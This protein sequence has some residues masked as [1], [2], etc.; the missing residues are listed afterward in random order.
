MT[1]MDKLTILAD[2]AKYDVACTSSGSD[3]AN[4]PGTL[5]S[6][7]AGGICHSFASDG[8]CIS[9]LKVLYSNAC[10]YD[11]SYCV[12]RSSNDV[13]RASFEQ[14]ELASLTIEFYRRNYLEGLFLS[15]G[16]LKNPNYTCELMH[17]ALSILRNEYN[18][19]GYIHVKAIPGADD[20]LIHALG[21]LADRI[22]VNIELPSRQSLELLAPDKNREDILRPMS[23]IKERIM[24]NRNE[25]AL[26]KRV[27]KFAPAGQA[28]QL[29]VGATPETDHQI[30]KLS[31]ALYKKY[32]LKRVFFS[33]YM[34]MGSSANLPSTDIKP[35]LLREHRLYQSDWLMRFYGFKADEIVSE[36]HPNLNPLIDPKCNWAINN[37]HVFPVEINTAPREML[38]RAPGIGPISANRIITA[39]R[40]GKL[41]FTGL[42]KLG[43]ILKRAQYFITCGGKAMPGVKMEPAAA[44]NG[45]LSVKSAIMAEGAYA[46][47]ISMFDLTE[48][49]LAACLVQQPELSTAMTAVLRA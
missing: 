23:R 31:S 38:L 15:S 9:L 48:E 49:E 6:A 8:R 44:L 41:D 40:M 37:M 17:N 2:A 26:F 1:T 33:A 45:L 5:G 25:I 7:V 13:P 36:R 42:K 39:R 18:F 21:L 22:S 11:C 32:S 10:A 27:P 43:V 12:N 46:R 34:P 4:R 28:T 19:N 16:V 3:R 47:Q 20:R 30:L 24:E 29:I 35:P 14:R